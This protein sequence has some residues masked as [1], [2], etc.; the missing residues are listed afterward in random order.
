MGDRNISQPS[1]AGALLTSGQDAQINLWM[2][3]SR[4]HEV[5]QN[6]WE[7]EDSLRELCERRETEKSLGELGKTSKMEKSLAALC[8][9]QIQLVHLT[10]SM[11][12]QLRSLQRSRPETAAIPNSTVDKAVNPYPSLPRNHASMTVD[13]EVAIRSVYLFVCFG[14]EELTNAIYEVKFKHGGVASEPLVVE[15]VNRFCE[16]EKNENVGMRGAVRIFHLSNLYVP[17]KDGGY[18]IDT[19]TMSRSSSFPPTLGYKSVPIFVSAYDK[20]YCL[21]SPFSISPILEPSFERFD[22]DTNMWEKMPP[23][24]ENNFDVVA[25]HVGRKQ[26]KPVE[27]DDS[28]YNAPFQGRA[29]VV[30]KTIYSLRQGEVIAFSLGLDKDDNGGVVYNLNQLFV[31]QGLE[32]A[33]PLFAFDM[34]WSEYLVHLGNNDFFHVKIECG[35]DTVPY[36]RITTFQ[37]VVG[38]GGRHMIKTIHSN[39]HSLDLEDVEWFNLLFCFTLECGDYER[40]EEESVTS[41]NQPKQVETS[42]DDNCSVVKQRR[43]AKKEARRGIAARKMRINFETGRW[44]VG[45]RA[46]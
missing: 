45:C 28:V 5:L 12:K 20:L 43:M 15:L 7:M 2:M 3:V 16:G 22:P 40:T 23:I 19:K 9:Q 31:L 11:S 17:T 8:A 27:V 42:L 10:K 32:V 39:V 29:V 44:E 25:F 41:M 38:E 24:R 6:I 36:L 21:A 30:G 4:N 37:I 18:I 34:C 1:A 14:S 35:N 33:D 26:W 13:P 46:S